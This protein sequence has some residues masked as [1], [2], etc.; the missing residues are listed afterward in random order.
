MIKVTKN[1]LFIFIFLAV[2]YSCTNDCDV[3]TDEFNPTPYSLEIP[4][5]LPTPTDVPVDNHLTKEGVS[6]GRML[7]YEPLLSRDGSHPV[8]LVIDKNGF[9]IQINLVLY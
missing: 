7:F 2:Q 5:S 3:P 1:S 8:P 9:L 6:L 4:S